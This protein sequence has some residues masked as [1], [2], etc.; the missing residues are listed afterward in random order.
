[1]IKFDID[2]YNNIEILKS[3]DCFL[4]KLNI[5]EDKKYANIKIKLS[6]DELDSLITKLISIK[7]E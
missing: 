2:E 6:E 1:M 3:K 7:A 5:K 4:L